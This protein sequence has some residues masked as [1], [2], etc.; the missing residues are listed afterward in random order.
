MVDPILSAESVKTERPLSDLRVASRI[1][2]QLPVVVDFQGGLTRGTTTELSLDGLALIID[3][4]TMAGN[5]VHIRFCIGRNLAYMNLSGYVMAVRGVTNP[6]G[7]FRLAIR[8]SV[9][10]DA[11]RTILGSCIRELVLSSSKKPPIT[12]GLGSGLESDPRS[13]ISLFVTDNPYL[14]EYRRNPSLDRNMYYDG[15]ASNVKIKS[16]RLTHNTS[17]RSRFH[18]LGKLVSQSSILIVELIRDFMVLSLPRTISKI[19]TPNIAFAFIAHPRDLSDVSRKVPFV[20]FLPAWLLKVWLRYQWP[21]VG[22]YI[23]GLKTKDGKELLGAMLITPLTAKQMLRNVRL[24]K[25][26]VHQTVK[27]AEKMGAKI[28]GLGAFTSIVTKD[29]QDLPDKV[30]VGITTGNSYS[31]AVAV[32]NAVMAALLTNLSL[33][34]ATAA[35]VGGAGSMGS[36]CVKLLARI[37]AKLILVDVNQ[38]GLVNLMKQLQGQS[39]QLEYTADVSKI[40]SADIVIAATNSPYTVIPAEH[41]KPGAI[42]VDAAQPKNVPEQVPLHRPD[43]LVIESAIVDSPGVDCHFDLGLRV[44]EALGCLSETMILSAN[45]WEGHYSLGKADPEYATAVTV[46]GRELGFR[47]AYFRNSLGYIT[48]KDLIRVAQARITT[49]F[50]V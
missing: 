16:A 17:N 22:S 38:N 6:T 47:L 28:V 45:G 44:G 2:V 46:V 13:I 26:R 31:A 30:S 24:A 27:L 29:G 5:R 36:A 23:T 40:K 48:E 18:R 15:P 8:F 37:V 49:S 9:M 21:I 4:P 25:K 34:H 20:R 41:L 7:K 12:N 33:P 19:F 32:Q 42:V 39:V 11:E 50:H 1:K 43:V 10:G 14:L 3:L 35:V